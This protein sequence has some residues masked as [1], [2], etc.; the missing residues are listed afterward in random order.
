MPIMRGAAIL[1][2]LLLAGCASAFDTAMDSV[3]EPMVQ[4]GKFAFLRCQDLVGQANSQESRVKELR[5]LMERSN[6]GMGGTAVNLFVYDPD[7]KE[8]EAMLRGIRKVQADKGCKE[9]KDGGKPVQ[10]TIPVA[11]PS[12]T[13]PTAARPATTATGNLGPLH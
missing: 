6:E 2:A 9:A 8:A 5:E 13:S 7:L 10:A 4:P 12:Q 1:T 11:P 3:G